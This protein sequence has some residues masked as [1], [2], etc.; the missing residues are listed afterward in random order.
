MAFSKAAKEAICLR[1]LLIEFGFEKMARTTLF[2]DS[3]GARMLAENPVHHN[4][5]KHI[6]TR[7]HFVRDAVETNSPSIIFQQTRWLQMLWPVRSLGSVST[8]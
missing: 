6:D 3:N 2:C 4:R 7:Y 5:S 1:R 8:S